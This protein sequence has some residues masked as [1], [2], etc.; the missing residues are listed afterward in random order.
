MTRLPSFGNITAG[1][2]LPLPGFNGVDTYEND[3]V[4]AILVVHDECNLT[5]CSDTLCNIVPV[6]NVL[7]TVVSLVVPYTRGNTNYY[8]SLCPHHSC[9]T[10]SLCS[11]DCGTN[12]G[13]NTN[14]T[15]VANI[16]A[17]PLFAGSLNNPVYGLYNHRTDR[18]SLT[19]N[20]CS[21][22]KY[23]VDIDKVP[24]CGQCSF[25]LV[26]TTG[27]EILG[28]AY[29]SGYRDGKRVSQVEYP[30]R[31]KSSAD[32]S[33]FTDTSLVGIYPVMYTQN[34]TLFVRVRVLSGGNNTFSLV[35]F[36][37]RLE[38][39]LNTGNQTEYWLFSSKSA[40]DCTACAFE[41]K[42][43]VLPRNQTLTY[44]ANGSR[45]YESPLGAQMSLS[46]DASLLTKVTGSI[47]SG[48]YLFLNIQTNRSAP[49][50]LESLYVCFSDK[51]QSVLYDPNNGDF[52]CLQPLIVPRTQLLTL[53]NKRVEQKGDFTLQ[54]INRTI[55]DGQILAFRLTSP[56]LLTTY[57]VHA[58]FSVQGV[59]D[60]AVA[61]FSYDEGL[62]LYAIVLIAVGSA[63]AAALF[64][65]TSVCIC[66]MTLITC[67]YI[68]GYRLNMKREKYDSSPLK[69]TKV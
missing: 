3:G 15:P 58:I 36:D 65:I 18:W 8:V 46:A 57:T 11:T 9:D 63:L 5:S 55:G 21:S 14:S 41:F 66:C 53:L 7:G 35:S 60:E 43:N 13:S 33:N 32:V 26:T 44:V 25:A 61:S 24:R 31:V 34:G 30:Y 17:S 1:R 28:A 2:Y 4:S 50:V 51:N 27:I 64:C 39:V 42:W 56:R 10:Y 48:S 40:P 59:V 45:S 38:R 20:G 37:P 23:S 12:K 16:G 19:A 62:P 68:F 47:G 69:V 52:G 49:V 22:V 29:F 6:G 67:G 54:I